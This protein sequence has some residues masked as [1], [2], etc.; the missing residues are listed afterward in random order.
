MP[1]N[2]QP[3][4]GQTVESPVMEDGHYTLEDR[5]NPSAS[6]AT[7]EL[8]PPNPPPTDSSDR[9]STS[10]QG[11]ALTGNITK[12]GL[13]RSTSITDFPASVLVRGPRRSQSKMGVNLGAKMASTNNE[14]RE[15]LRDKAA[16]T[17]PASSTKDSEIWIEEEGLRIVVDI[18]RIMARAY[19][20][21]AMNKFAE[22]MPEF[23]R[24]PFEHLESGWVQC[25]LGKCKFEMLDYASAARYFEHA[26]ELEPNL[27][28][29]M[30]IYST[31]L[32]QLRKEM[33]LSTLA[34]ELKEANHQSP[35]AWVALGN[36]Y[37]LKHESDQALKCFQRAIQL[38]DRFAYAHTLSGLEYSELE[39]YD[40]A[41][42]EFRT[43]MSIDPRHY[44]AWYGMGVI[45]NKMGK[46]DLA[47]IHLKEAHKLN[48]SNSVLL[49]L[50][51]TIQEKMN[52]T[53]EA[54]RSFEQAIDLDPT[55]VAARFRKALVQYDMEQYDEALK[56]LEAVMKLS[57]DEANVFV[58]QGRV[59]LKMG[60]KEQALR[61]F[62]WAL[63]LDSK[64]SHAIRDLIEK[65]NYDS[66]NGRD[67]YEVKIDMD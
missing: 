53:T 48:P 38:N 37:S 19:G 67:G 39:E 51:G 3:T 13:T 57:P 31:C 21:L 56:E 54:L 40:K 47:L 66:E 5:P 2:I 22:A 41:Q 11:Q 45:Y 62:T 30:E 17:I 59:L 16:P 18:F 27:Q 50:V 9:S 8:S 6:S 60:N 36:A 20:L 35:Q 12:K 1:S 34:K 32:W 46:N 10:I 61:Y 55:N 43:A 14:E 42:T 15:Q 64:S 44:N 52:R 63:N 26:R 28:R 29:D 33:V 49:Y 24:L 23:E 25:Q 7:G 58:L 65:V 4:L